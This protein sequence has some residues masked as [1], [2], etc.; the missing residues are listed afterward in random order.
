MP[1]VA[2]G[3]AVATGGTSV[4]GFDPSSGEI[5]WDVPRAEGLVVPPAIE[6][7]SEGIVAFV[8]GNTPTDSKLVGLDPTSHARLFEVELG[9]L[10]RTA[11]SISGGLVFVG[12][13]E[14]AVKAVDLTSGS[15]AWSAQTQGLVATSPAVDGGRVFVVSEDEQ[16]EISRLYALQA[17][18]G[19]VAWT[20]SPPGISL[21]VSSATVA[22]GSVLVGFGDSTVR[23]FDPASGA[24][25]WTAPVRAPF[26]PR[27]TPAVAS[28][29]VF[30]MDLGGGVYRFDGRTGEVVW[31]YQFP[32]LAEW[33]SPLVVGETV[34]VGLDDGTIA[35]IRVASGHVVWQTRLRQGAIGPFAPAGDLLLAPVIGPRGGVV[36]FERAPDRALVDVPSP[37]ELDLPGAL[38]NFL[39]G[40]AAVLVALL[41]L[42]RL[43]LPRLRRAR[44][45]S[46]P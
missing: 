29:S 32:S 2:S 35:A 40:S 25:R 15:Q 6:P 24:L 9:G 7:G 38:V 8:E 45:V 17:S 20:F 14:Q 33:G 37:S 44:H 30:A 21:G 4:V 1:A 43:A 28:G 41:L 11:P 39:A 31:D 36:A 34:Y 42:F 23:A 18:D 10:S 19:R 5:L 46:P 22:D 27:S 3:L 26:S 16:S 13:Q 12:T